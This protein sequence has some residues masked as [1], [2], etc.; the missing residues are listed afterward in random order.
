MSESPATSHFWV[1]NPPFFASTLLVASAGDIAGEDEPRVV[2]RLE[3][4]DADGDKVNDVTVEFPAGE[5][6]VIDLEPFSQALKSQG[7]VSHG[8]LAVSSPDGTRHLCRQTIGG[9][10]ALLQDPLLTKGRDASF[11]P[12]II[13]ARREHQ[14]VLVNASSEPAQVAIRLFYGN[15]ISLESELLS[16]TEDV[17]W[18][19]GAIQAYMRIAPRLQASVSCHVIERVPGETPELDTF[20]CLATW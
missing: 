11:T 1:A 4:F 16:S 2:T 7:G 19:K 8:H 18:E 10:V 15:L 9:S 6:G 14:I 5:V 13:G 17:S 3:L 12:L 20:R